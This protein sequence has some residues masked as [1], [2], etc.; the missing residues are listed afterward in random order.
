M[1]LSCFRAFCKSTINSRL[2]V[3]TT[4][5]CRSLPLDLH[6]SST[7]TSL[8]GHASAIWCLSIHPTLHKMFFLTYPF[9]SCAMLFPWYYKP[10]VSAQ[11]SLP[12]GSLLCLSYLQDT[13]T[14]SFSSNLCLLKHLS[15]LHS[16]VSIFSTLFLKPEFLRD[17]LVYTTALAL[18]YQIAQHLSQYITMFKTRLKQFLWSIKK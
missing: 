11:I 3:L 9:P 1:S 4:E 7:Q 5:L 10:K 13:P 12:Q 15:Y 8:S 18:A 17:C 16:P 6:P 14:L 2:S